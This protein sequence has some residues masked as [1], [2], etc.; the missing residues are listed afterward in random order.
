MAGY[1]AAGYA[2][3][4]AAEVISATAIQSAWRGS[5]VRGAL[6]RPKTRLFVPARWE[7]PKGTAW[8]PG[9]RM[10]EDA[11]CD[12]PCAFGLGP[13]LLVSLLRTPTPLPVHQRFAPTRLLLHGAWLAVY[14]RNSPLRLLSGPSGAAGVRLKSAFS[15]A[16]REALFEDMWRK[17]TGEAEASREVLLK[18]ARTIEKRLNFPDT[19]RAGAMVAGDPSAILAPFFVSKT[20]MDFLLEVPRF[21][22]IPPSWVA[23]LE[24]A[25][26]P[27]TAA[28]ADAA[29]R[30]S[31]AH[32]FSE[33]AAFGPYARHGSGRDAAY[34]S[35][36][37]PSSIGSGGD[38]RNPYGL[39]FSM[40]SFEPRRL[41]ED[42]GGVEY[43]PRPAPRGGTRRLSNRR[44]PGRAALYALRTGSPRPQP[45]D[46]HCAGTPPPRRPPP[47]AESPRTHQ[48]MQ[49]HELG[50]LAPPPS[51]PAK[52]L[53]LR[54][55]VESVQLAPDSYHDLLR[56]RAARRPPS[57]R[58]ASPRRV[59][60]RAREALAEADAPPKVRV[61]I[62]L[63]PC[64]AASP[65]ARDGAPAA[66]E[67]DAIA[68]DAAAVHAE[69]VARFELEGPAAEEL[70]WNLLAA[71]AQAPF[72]S[73]RERAIVFE[74]RACPSPASVLSSGNSGA[75]SA[76]R[77][78]G[79][80]SLDL[81]QLADAADLRSARLPVFAD[82]G[83]APIAWLRVSTDAQA[84]VRAARQHALA[85]DAANVRSRSARAS[86][87]AASMNRTEFA[88]FEDE[89]M[90]G[91]RAVITSV[92]LLL[93]LLLLLVILA[94][95][96]IAIVIAIVI[97]ISIRIIILIVI[98]IIVIITTPPRMTE[99]PLA[100][101]RGR[102]RAPFSARRRDA[103]PRAR[104]QLAARVHAASSAARRG[105]G[106][107]W[108]GLRTPAALAPRAALVERHAAQ[109]HAA[110][111]PRVAVARLH[112]ATSALPGGADA[113]AAAAAGAAI[114]AAAAT[115]PAAASPAAPAPRLAV[116]VAAA[117]AVA[118]AGEQSAG[119][120]S[121]GERFALA[122]CYA[123]RRAVGGAR[124][125]S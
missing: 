97:S 73:D 31:Q 12:D 26:P 89:R 92:V 35:S 53:Q 76:G 122:R 84:A 75:R 18:E 71:R 119:R 8:H 51:L 112:A 99:G 107:G 1:A 45:H 82:G 24:R 56:E 49:V 29:R 43:P 47:M 111:G 64:L 87:L 60:G 32:G 94:S 103:A 7:P 52:V 16:E 91:E 116:A 63:P 41:E 59:P 30:A 70:G 23:P 37:S 101:R 114:T 2:R 72:A 57:A 15:A 27:L 106:G 67:A 13:Q 98:L 14:G 50:R 79:V 125:G 78:F 34:S 4:G 95:V 105:G 40:P 19:T 100:Q 108:V 6:E 61:C 17:L 102:A 93:L 46:S 80:A 33:P 28:A 110:A 3:G 10:F 48:R 68:D 74:L 86:A 20:L 88:A 123:R 113:G 77:L 25:P 104:P 121:A 120:Q 81:A 109:R 90:H 54:A 96:N 65:P 22:K 83:G 115:L 85:L 124:R 55:R 69:V 118:A 5:S 9:Q 58:A 62:V 39:G 42:D 117:L 66:T 38:G 11:V 36:F 44:A 21:L